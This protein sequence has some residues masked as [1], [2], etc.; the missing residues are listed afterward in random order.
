HHLGGLV[1]LRGAGVGYDRLGYAHD[2]EHGANSFGLSQ[3]G[4]EWVLE[5]R[6][7]N[8][9]KN[10]SKPTLVPRALYAGVNLSQNQ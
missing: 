10:A 5:F 4:M 8:W 6:E 7:S 9:L 1:G 3:P 2:I